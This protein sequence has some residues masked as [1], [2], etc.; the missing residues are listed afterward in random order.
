MLQYIK[1]YIKFL[2][3]IQEWGGGMVR[4]E[5]RN[6]H[7][8]AKAFDPKYRAKVGGTWELVTHMS[9][10]GHDNVTFWVRKDY[11]AP[12]EKLLRREYY[13]DGKLVKVQHKSNERHLGGKGTVTEYI[14]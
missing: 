14:K 8:I 5:L 4:S 12:H 1:N 13:S 11:R 3:R 9:L 7:E 6:A 2:F 10:M